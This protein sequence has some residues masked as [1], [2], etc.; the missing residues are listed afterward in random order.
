MICQPCSNGGEANRH[1]DYELAAWLHTKCRDCFCQ[2]R[3]GPG[4]AIVPAVA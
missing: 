3:V 4:T 1:G 2:H